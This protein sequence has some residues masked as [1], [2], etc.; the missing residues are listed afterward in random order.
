LRVP[1]QGLRAVDAEALFRA[2]GIRGTSRDIQAYLKN[3]CDCH[4]LVIG[5]LAGLVNDYLPDRGNFDAWA[6]D[7]G[8]GDSLNL[9]ELDLVQKRNH[10]L[11]AAFAAL[12]E[13]SR[14]LLS[15]LALL[16]SAVDYPTLTAL[17]PYLPPASE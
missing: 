1:L 11:R 7:P 15:T 9:S 13:K 4:P 17:N 16:S 10:I 14:Q 3:H 6:A 2:C 8:G 5:V 12:P